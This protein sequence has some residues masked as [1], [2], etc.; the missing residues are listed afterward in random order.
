MCGYTDDFVCRAWVLPRASPSPR[1]TMHARKRVRLRSADCQPAFASGGFAAA[2]ARRPD[3][4]LAARLREIE[5]CL[6]QRGFDL[7]AAPHQA[8][9]Q[10]VQAPDVLRM[11]AG[12]AELAVIAEIGAIDRL[13]L[14][15]ATLL[16]QQRSERMPRRLHPAPRFVVGQRVVEFDRTPQM[17]EAGVDVAASIL[18]LA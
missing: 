3:R 10:A 11:L 7:V 14:L 18:E 2:E 16:Q 6:D 15:D 13:R 5:P 12:A 8:F 4:H 9:V 17:G 1:T